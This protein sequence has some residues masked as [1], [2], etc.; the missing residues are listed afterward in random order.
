VSRDRREVIAGSAT[1]EALT[2]TGLTALAADAA[3]TATAAAP[4]PRSTVSRSRRPASAIVCRCSPPAISSGSALRASHAEAR[5][6]GRGRDVR[7]IFPRRRADFALAFRLQA[8]VVMMRALSP[9]I[10]AAVLSAS[11]LALAA[12]STLEVDAARGAIAA[13]RASTAR[14]DHAHPITSQDAAFDA[15]PGYVSAYREGLVSGCSATAAQAGVGSKADTLCGCFGEYFDSL[16]SMRATVIANQGTSATKF[17]TQWPPERADLVPLGEGELVSACGS[18]AYKSDLAHGLKRTAGGVGL[19]AG[20]IAAAAGSLA[21]Y[22]QTLPVGIPAPDMFGNPMI[23]EMPGVLGMSA[24]TVGVVTFGIEIGA[25]LAIAA[26]ILITYEG[27]AYLV[28][29]HQ[30]HKAADAGRTPTL[31]PPALATS[32]GD[33]TTVARRSNTRGSV[34]TGSSPAT[35]NAGMHH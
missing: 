18:P 28:R 5:A 20:G 9:S 27:V 32:T 1:L 3:R 19:V 23:F 13:A 26:G 17:D 12:P 11:S 2:F 10:V 4:A 24:A 21:V 25:C 22:V 6:P 31:P 34:P 33:G 35:Q 7:I 15:E 29:A 16:P 30:E 14:L 8:W